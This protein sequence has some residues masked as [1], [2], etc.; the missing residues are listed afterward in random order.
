MT[1][2]RLHEEAK[3]HNINIQVEYRHPRV[4]PVGSMLND[5]TKI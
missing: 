5:V 4:F 1:K 2:D 3:K